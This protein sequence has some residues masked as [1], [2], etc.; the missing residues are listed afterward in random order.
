MHRSHLTATATPYTALVCVLPYR[1]RTRRSRV[2]RS[3]APTH[4]P[5]SVSLVS[6]APRSRRRKAC[7]NA[8]YKDARGEE[9]LQRIKEMLGQSCC[10]CSCCGR[11][12]GRGVLWIL[13]LV[14]HG[15]SPSARRPHRGRCSRRRRARSRPPQTRGARRGCPPSSAR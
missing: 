2:R 5:V 8:I 12:C 4:A 9:M 6:P 14:T 3:L 10:S 11:G 7:K 15:V 1:Y 13:L